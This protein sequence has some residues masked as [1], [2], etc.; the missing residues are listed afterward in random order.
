MGSGEDVDWLSRVLES[1]HNEVYLKNIEYFYDSNTQTSESKNSP[2]GSGR[3]MNSK[4][5]D[6]S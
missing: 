3:L 6:L 1:L 5:L 4:E 2:D